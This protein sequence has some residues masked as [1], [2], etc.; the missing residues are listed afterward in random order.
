MYGPISGIID[1]L[2][3]CGYSPDFF[4]DAGN[5]GIYLIRD[6]NQCIGEC[7][8]LISYETDGDKYLAKM[9]HLYGNTRGYCSFDMDWII[10]HLLEIGQIP[11]DNGMPTKGVMDSVASDG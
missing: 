4:D 11:N 5:P 7:R 1:A 3:K 10:G 9:Q 2:A 6:D 8:T